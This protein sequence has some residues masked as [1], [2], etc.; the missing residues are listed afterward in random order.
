MELHLGGVAAR[1]GGE[2]QRAGVAEQAAV[3]QVR[4]E[5]A[6]G[7]AAAHAVQ[8]RPGAEI[9]VALARGARPTPRGGSASGAQTQ[10][11]PAARAARSRGSAAGRAMAASSAA[12]SRP[13]AV[14]SRDPAMRPARPPLAPIHDASILLAAAESL[15]GAISPAPLP[16]KISSRAPRGDSPHAAGSASRSIPTRSRSLAPTASGV[17]DGACWP[18]RVKNSRAPFASSTEMTRST[19]AGTI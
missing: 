1:G 11:G 15:S 14:K 9:P 4:G 8:G 7:E 16:E 18:A 19:D 10:R 2:E 3:E 5:G 12:A 13:E 6:G 17:S